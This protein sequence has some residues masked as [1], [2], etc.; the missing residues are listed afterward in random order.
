MKTFILYWLIFCVTF[1][2]NPYEFYA[3]EK[4][5]NVKSKQS[6]L[7]KLNKSIND[8]RKKINLL[9]KKEKTTVKQINANKKLSNELSRYLLSLENQLNVL[10]QNIKR[11][12][13]IYYGL[14]SKLGKIYTTYAAL[15][16]KSYIDGITED[17]EVLLTKKSYES[18]NKKDI[19]IKYLT[20]YL[21][22]AQ[23][24][25]NFQRVEISSRTGILRDKSDEQENLKIVKIHEKV[26]VTKSINQNHNLLTQIKRDT[27]TLE[28]ELA[29]K[30]Q[31]AQKIR[32]IIS[33][34]IKKDAEKVKTV[35]KSTNK[36]SPVPAP[37]PVTVTAMNWPV[38]SRRIF[39]DYGQIRNKETNTIFENPGIDILTASGSSVRTIADGEISLVHWLPGY[40]SLIII[41]HGAGFRSVYANLSSIN[42]KKGDRVQKGNSIGR[43]GASIEGE[44][45]HFELW[46][47]V[48]RL[49]PRTY[50]H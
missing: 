31:S 14:S 32:Q 15:A 46:Q 48:S 34:L 26:S 6:E 45:L 41:N 39:R 33:N 25:I 13:S 22:D 7:D 20:K 43:T 47:G 16:R 11:Q 36:I 27:K 21:A 2:L 50:L 12:D 18:E 42:V 38:D 4:V 28:K 40:G 10:Q 19:Y 44:F 35:P 23:Q 5:V 29:I 24:K 30:T 8:T 3:K 17:S 9:N 1:C 49:N 37:K